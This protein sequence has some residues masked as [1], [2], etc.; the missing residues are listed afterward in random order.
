MNLH[1]CVFVAALV[2]S[3]LSSAALSKSNDAKQQLKVSAQTLS[4]ML[5]HGPWPPKPSTHTAIDPSN[6]V[7]GNKDAIEFG[8]QLFTSTYLSADKQTSCISCHLPTHAFSGD[9]ASRSKNATQPTTTTSSSAKI[10]TH[11]LDRD[12]QTLMNVRFNRWFGWDG[13][14]DNLWA[15]SIRPIIHT[16]EM[17]LA[18]EDIRK[19]ANSKDFTAQYTQLFGDSQHQSDEEVLVNIGK[20]LAA[21]QETL[22]TDKTPFDEFRDAVAEQ[23]WATAANYP[24][25][26]QRGLEIFEGRGRCSFCHQ[27]ALFTNGEFHDAGVPYF[28]RPGVVDKGRHQGMIELKKSPF[29]LDGKYNDDPEKQ[30]AWAVRKVTQLHSN[31][32]IFR[33][34]SLRNV[35]KTA[36]YMHNGSLQTLEDVV[37]HYNNIDMERL[38]ADGEAILKPLGLTKDEVNDLV[39]FLKSLSD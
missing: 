2:L 26:A 10:N 5:A 35:A 25:S 32:G 18:I 3:G 37:Q 28:I 20:A 39:E 6:R 9:S 19:V 34:P 29:T 31:F 12:T 24:E 23:D 36:P 11:S 17:N 4:S 21:F 15:Q 13:R 7:S 14:N 27:G 1:W 38:H 30:G 33:V 16:T 8:K 22:V